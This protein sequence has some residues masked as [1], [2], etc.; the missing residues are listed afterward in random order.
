MLDRTKE[1]CVAAESA[2]RN[3]PDMTAETVFADGVPPISA[4]ESRCLSKLKHQEYAA[5]NT[6]WSFNKFRGRVTTQNF[7]RNFEDTAVWLSLHLSRKAVAEYLRISWDTVGPIISRVEKEISAHHQPLDNLVN[8]GIDETSYKK[9]HK[10]IT[11]I[12]NH[13]TNTVVWAAKG[14]GK[15]VL[16]PFFKQL[17]SEQ[18]SKIR[19]VSGDGARWIKETIDEYCQT[20]NFALTRSMSCHGAPRF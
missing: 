11:V 14:H 20:R 2:G 17:S 1:T 10:Y 7:T 13:D 19:L 5:R 16:E 3:R 4:V 8:I 15:S 12:V 18:R 9:G 6:V